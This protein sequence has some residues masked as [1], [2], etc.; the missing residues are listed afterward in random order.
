M[1]RHRGPA[2]DQTLMPLI[3]RIIEQVLGLHNIIDFHMH[4][5]TSPARCKALDIPEIICA[6]EVRDSDRFFD[7]IHFWFVFLYC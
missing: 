4:T 5:Q 1:M 6:S 7:S 2:G 3:S